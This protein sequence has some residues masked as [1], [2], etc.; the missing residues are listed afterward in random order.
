M[1]PPMTQPMHPLVEV[2]EHVAREARKSRV[3][4]I[5]DLDSTLFC[6]SPRTQHILRSLGEQPEFSSKHGPVAE[7]LRKIEVL[8]SDYSVREVLARSHARPDPEVADAIRAHWKK[9]FF[10]SEFLDRDRLYPSANEYVNHLHDLG[11][12]VLY[13]TGRGESLMREGT[14]AALRRENFPLFEDT[15]LMMK[16][17]DL[18]TDEFFKVRALRD[19]STNYDHIWFFE[20][21][22]LIIE[23]VREALPH[24]HI[25]FVNSNHSGKK[26]APQGLRTITP[27]FKMPRG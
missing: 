8:P 17:S 11:A 5:F 15:R 9:Y 10:S 19:L 13:L 21:E 3:A 7:V 12:E 2:S 14:I 23:D 16:P 18:E 27:N 4:V 26:P 25:V 6:V 24:V 1:V 20:N 22:P